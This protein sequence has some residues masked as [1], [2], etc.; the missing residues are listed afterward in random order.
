MNINAIIAQ[1]DLQTSWFMN[2]LENISDEESNIQST[3]QLNPIK[4]V[5]GHLTDTRLTVYSILTG[6]P[7][8]EMYKKHFGKGSSNK[9]DSA[10][11]KIE[12]VK[13]D[14]VHIS[15]RLKEVLQTLPE[16]KLLASPPFQ[17]SIPD[18]TLLGLIAYF[19]IHES[20]HLGQISVL[21][22]MIGK[23]AM[24]MGR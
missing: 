20:F 23:D 4:W 11:P 21:R 13:A 2:A 14:W 7:G 18:K 22:K 17:V 1:F 10:F 6:N 5:A 16:E 8:N 19:A 3:E 24:S 15:I 12:Q 9:P